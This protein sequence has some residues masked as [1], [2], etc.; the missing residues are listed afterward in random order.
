MVNGLS[1]EKSGGLLEQATQD[2]KLLSLCV[3]PTQITTD[4]EGIQ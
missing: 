3:L 4:I 2:A 1:M